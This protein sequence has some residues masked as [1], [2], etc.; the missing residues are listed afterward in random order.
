MTDEWGTLMFEASYGGFPIYVLSTDD[1]GGRDLVR[2]KYPHRDGADIEDMG[3]EARVTR[4]RL[5]F[6]GDGHLEAFRVFHDLAQS[7]EA[8]DF[9]HPLTGTYSAKVGPLTFSAQAEP[10]DCIMVEC[11][12]EEDTL[13]PAAFPVGVGSPTLS[14]VDDVSA[15]AAAL[16]DVIVVAPEDGT[17]IETDEVDFPDPTLPEDAL[18]TATAW[19]A[20]AD[21]TLRDVTYE[22]NALTARIQIVTNQL[23]VATDLERYDTMVALINLTASLRR[24]A[25][26]FAASAP[27]LFRVTVAAPTPLMILAVQLYGAKEAPDRVTQLMSLND[28]RNPARVER[29]TVLLAQTPATSQRLRSPR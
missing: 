4:C 22:L 8:L 28:I 10:R 14:G 26:V 11:S 15:S 24:A 19:E 21:K 2:H 29:G 18:A 20:D 13:T 7:I 9:V 3:G 16:R 25:Q 6:F 5:I 17:F 27:Q 1:T 12:F 23:E